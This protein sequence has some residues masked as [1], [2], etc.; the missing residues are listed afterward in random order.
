M[1]FNR[2]FK[3]FLLSVISFSEIH[4]L[5]RDQTY[6]LSTF[7]KISSEPIGVT[8]NGKPDETDKTKFVLKH[9]LFNKDGISKVPAYENTTM[10]ITTGVLRLFKINPDGTEEVIPNFEINNASIPPHRET[11]VKFPPYQITIKYTIDQQGILVI[12]VTKVENEKQIEF[13]A[14]NEPIYISTKSVPLTNA[15]A[16][17]KTEFKVELVGNQNPLTPSNLPQTRGDYTFQGYFN[18]DTQAL[19]SGTIRLFKIGPNNETIEVEDIAL[20]KVQ[21]FGE[22]PLP[23]KDSPYNIILEF[24]YKSPTSGGEKPYLLINIAKAEIDP[25]YTKTFLKKNIPIYISSKPSIGIDTPENVQ[26]KLKILDNQNGRITNEIP[27]TE[28]GNDFQGYFNLD[29]QALTSGSLRLVKIGPNGEEI[30]IPDDKTKIIPRLSGEQ[31]IP[32]DPYYNVNIIFKEPSNEYSWYDPRRLLPSPK[33]LLFNIQS[34]QIDNAKKRELREQKATIQSQIEALQ[35]EIDT[36]AAELDNIKLAIKLSDFLSEKGYK[37]YAHVEILKETYKNSLQNLQQDLERIKQEEPTTAKNSL[38]KARNDFDLLKVNIENLKILNERLTSINKDYFLKAASTLHNVRAED[39]LKRK[40]E[41]TNKLLKLKSISFYNATLE[42]ID[43]LTASFKAILREIQDLSEKDRINLTINYRIQKNPPFEV[44]NS[45]YM[46]ESFLTSNT[47]GNYKTNTT[48]NYYDYWEV[49]SKDLNAVSTLLI[50]SYA[51]KQTDTKF[52]IENPILI[53]FNKLGEQ[54]FSVSD[55]NSGTRF[56]VI[57][58]VS[59]QPGAG[60]EN[61]IKLAKIT[62][63]NVTPGQNDIKAF[64]GTPSPSNWIYIENPMYNKNNIVLSSSN[65]LSDFPELN[66]LN[67]N[68]K[69]SPIKAINNIAFLNLKIADKNRNFTGTFDINLPLKEEDQSMEI[70][71]PTENPNV[72]DIYKITFKLVSGQAHD[73]NFKDYIKNVY[74]IEVTDIQ[75]LESSHKKELAHYYLLQEDTKSNK[76]GDFIANLRFIPIENALVTTF[77]DRKFYEINSNQNTAEVNIELNK[78]SAEGSTI[79]LSDTKKII[80]LTP[81][82]VQTIQDELG[83]NFQITIKETENIVEP[84]ENTI[85]TNH[86]FEVAK[87]AIPPQNEIITQRL[88]PE[89]VEVNEFYTDRNVIVY[90]S[91]KLWEDESFKDLGY[92]PQIS[93]SSYSMTLP[94]GIPNSLTQ[95]GQEYT[96]TSKMLNENS[97]FATPNEVQESIIFKSVSPFPQNK[98]DKVLFTRGSINPNPVVFEDLYG[99]KFICNLELTI[100]ELPI[101]NFKRGISEKGKQFLD[102]KQNNTVEVWFIKIKSVE[103]I[104]SPTARG[105]LQAKLNQEQAQKEKEIKRKNDDQL[106]LNQNAPVYFDL[107]PQKIQKINPAIEATTG[108]V[109]FAL[110][111][112]GKSDNEID[113]DILANHNIPKERDRGT[114]VTYANTQ[115][116]QLNAGSGTVG[117]VA[118]VN[119]Q[120]IPLPNITIPFMTGGYLTE[121]LS[122]PIPVKIPG[123]PLEYI[124]TVAFNHKNEGFVGRGKRLYYTARIASVTYE[125][126]SE[127]LLLAAIDRQNKAKTALEEAKKTREAEIAFL[128]INDPI[129]INPTPF[130]FNNLEFTLIIKGNQLNAQTIL[131]E[132]ADGA[133]FA[134]F[135]NQDGTI[136]SGDLAVTTNAGQIALLGKNVEKTEKTYN[137]EIEG[138]PYI[139]TLDAAYQLGQTIQSTGPEEQAQNIPSKYILNLKNIQINQALLD[140]RAE[141]QRLKAEEDRKAQFLAQNIPVYID[142][143][144]IDSAGKNVANFKLAIENPITRTYPSTANDQAQANNP[145]LSFVNYLNKKDLA[146][147]SFELPGTSNII[148][149]SNGEKIDTLSILQS[150]GNYTIPISRTDENNNVIIYDAQIS[151]SGNNKYIIVKLNSPKYNEAKTKFEEN[152]KATS[153]ILQNNYPIYISRT[154][155]N[156]EGLEFSLGISGE[157]FVTAGIEPAINNNE[158]EGFA[159]KLSRNIYDNRK[160]AL[161]TKDKTIDLTGTLPANKVDPSFVT[162]IAVD[163]NIIPLDVKISFTPPTDTAPYYIIELISIDITE[164]EKANRAEAIALEKFIDENAAVYIDSTAIPS[165]PYSKANQNTFSLKLE[166]PNADIRKG[167]EAQVDGIAFS[168][169]YNKTNNTFETDHKLSV[170]SNNNEINNSSLTKL[171]QNKDIIIP[172]TGLATLDGKNYQIIVESKFKKS[173]IKG[174]PDTYIIKLKEVVNL[175][176]LNQ[177]FQDLTKDEQ[178]TILANNLPLYISGKSA[179][180]PDGSQFTININGNTIGPI[181]PP[182]LVK[183]ENDEIF[184]GYADKATYKI[185]SGNLDIFMNNQPIALKEPITILQASGTR[186]IR[187]PESAYTNSPYIVVLEFQKPTDS[188]SVKI[189]EIKTVNEAILAKENEEAKSDIQALANNL[190]TTLEKLASI[191]NEVKSNNGSIIQSKNAIDRKIQELSNEIKTVKQAKNIAED[192]LSLNRINTDITTLV[193][194]TSDLIFQYNQELTTSIDHNIIK[195]DA[196]KEINANIKSQKD[197]II[198]KSNQLKQFIQTLDVANNKIKSTEI[199]DFKDLDQLIQNL[200]KANSDFES[201][202]KSITELSTDETQAKDNMAFNLNTLRS[203]ATSLLEKIDIELIPSKNANL[204]NIQS[205]TEAKNQ[206]LEQ[207]ITELKNNLNSFINSL[208]PENIKTETEYKAKENEFNTFNTNFDNLKQELATLVDENNSAIESKKNNISNIAKRLLG[209]IFIDNEDPLNRASFTIN[210]AF[211]QDYKD[212]R[213]EVSDL[214]A[215]IS[216]TLDNLTEKNEDLKNSLAQIISYKQESENLKNLITQLIEKNNNL[217]NEET[218]NKTETEILIDQANRLKT[219]VQDLQINLNSFNN[220]LLANKSL[221]PENKFSNRSNILQSDNKALL[222][223]I[224]NILT[225]LNANQKDLGTTRTNLD[226]LQE[227]LIKETKEFNILKSEF[228]STKTSFIQSQSQILNSVQSLQQ[229]IA[230][231]KTQLNGVTTNYAPQTS[232]NIKNF[233]SE[234]N[235]LDSKINQL[236]DNIRSINN[237]KDLE[238]AK[239]E[240]NLY[241]INYND[242]KNQLDAIKYAEKLGSEEFSNTIYNLNKTADTLVTNI[243][244]LINKIPTKI[245]STLSNDMENL[246]KNSQELLTHVRELKTALEEKTLSQVSL[247]Q[248]ERELSEADN[249]LSDFDN[250]LG[251]LITSNIKNINSREGIARKA[252]ELIESIDK[253]PEF[254]IS[255]DIKTISYALETV[256][257]SLQKQIIDIHANLD[258]IIKDINNPRLELDNTKNNVDQIEVNLLKLKRAINSF[259][260]QNQDE[261]DNNIKTERGK[262]TDKINNLIGNIQKNVIDKLPDITDSNLLTDKDTLL[263]E[264]QELVDDI[265]LIEKSIKDTTSETIF[266]QINNELDDRNEKINDLI[267]RINTLIKDNSNN[268]ESKN[269][270]TQKAR[271]LIDIIDTDKDLSI[272]KNIKSATS[273]LDGIKKSYQYQLN[274]IRNELNEKIINKIDSRS[275]D[276]ADAR[277][278]LARNETDIN[279]LKNTINLFLVQNQRELDAQLIPD[280]E[281]LSKQVNSLIDNVNDNIIKKL[282]SITDFGLQ[283]QKASIQKEAEE[284]LTDIN[285]IKKSINASFVTQTIFDQIKEELSIKN[286]TFMDLLRSVDA[287]ERKNTN[288]IESRQKL[289]LEVNQ[290]I[291]TIDNDKNLIIPNNTPLASSEISN[292]KI[293]FQNQLETIRNNLVDISETIN[294]RY[295]FENIQTKVSEAQKIINALK[296]LIPNLLSRNQKELNDKINTQ[297]SGL[298]QETEAL[299]KGILTINDKLAAITDP[300]L[301]VSKATLQGDVDNFLKDLNEIDNSIDN[302]NQSTFSEIKDQLNDKN[303]T[304]TALNQRIGLLATQNAANIESKDKIKNDVNKLLDSLNDSEFII[305][306]D[307]PSATPT[308]DGTKQDLIN[309]LHI[310]RHD[311]GNILN[312]IDTADLIDSERNLDNVQ[313]NIINLKKDIK[314]FLS[315]NQQE[316]SSQIQA[317]RDSLNP[318]ANDLIENIKSNVLAKLPTIM[319]PA[320]LSEKDILAKDAEGFLTDLNNIKTSIN[321]PHTSPIIFEQIKDELII[322]NSDLTTLMQ[323]LNSLINLNTKYLE[324]RTD[325]SAQ[326]QALIDTIDNDPKLKIPSDLK[327]AYPELD[328]IKNFLKNQLIDTRTKLE[329]IIKDKD[330]LQFDFVNTS[331][332]LS[333]AKNNIE[334]LRNSINNFLNRNKDEIDKQLNSNKNTLNQRANALIKDLENQILNKL[335]SLTDPTLINTKNEIQ[336]DAENLLSDIKNIIISI[337]ASNITQPILGQIEEELP[338]RRDRL[339][340]LIQTFNSFLTQNTNTIKSKQN[341]E[342]QAKQLINTIDNDPTL[343]IPTDLQVASSPLDATK[344]DLISQLKTVRQKLHNILNNINTETFA[345]TETGLTEAQQTINILRTSIQEFLTKNNQEFNSQINNIKNDLNSQ[346]DTLIKNTQ[347]EISNKLPSITDLALTIRKNSLQKDTEEFLTDLNKIQTSINSGPLSLFIFNQINDELMSRKTIYN[348]LIK[349]MIELVND[350]QKNIDLRSNIEK[351]ATDYLKD[352]NTNIEYTV[353]KDLEFVTSEIDNTKNKLIDQINTARNGL[354]T[355]IKKAKEVSPKFDELQSNLTDIEKKLPGLKNSIKNFLAQYQKGL[356]IKI[357]ANRTSLNETVQTLFDDIKLKVIDKLPL[358]ADPNLI[359][360]KEEIQK[361]AKEFLT[362]LTKNKEEIADPAAKQADFDRIK[363]TLSTRSEEL[364]KLIQRIE[365][366]ISQNTINKNLRDSI[367]NQAKNMLTSINKDLAIPADFTP[368]AGMKEEQIKLQTTL[369]RSRDQ[370]RAAIT[371]IIT[372]INDKDLDFSAEQNTLNDTQKAINSLNE[373]IQ[374]LIKNNKNALAKEQA[375]REEELKRAEELRKQAL[376]EWTDKFNILQLKNQSLSDP[377][378]LDTKNQIAQEINQ[379]KENLLLDLSPEKNQLTYDAI[380]TKIDSAL[381]LQEKNRQIKNKQIQELEQQLKSLQNQP[382]VYIDSTP[383]KFNNKEFTV[384]LLRQH[385]DKKA[386]LKREASTLEFSGYVNSDGIILPNGFLAIVIK[387]YITAIKDKKLPQN[388]SIIA[389][390]EDEL[391]HPYIVTLN[392]AFTKNHSVFDPNLNL[393]NKDLPNIYIIKLA[394]VQTNEAKINDRIKA[395]DKAKKD[396]L[397][398]KQKT[399]HAADRDFISQN[400]P[401]YINQS[402]QSPSGGSLRL[403]LTTSEGMRAILPSQ[404]DGYR[405]S[406]YASQNGNIYKGDLFVYLNNQVAYQVASGNKPIG[407]SGSQ[408][409]SFTIG[410]ATYSMKIKSE[411]KS[412]AVSAT[413]TKT[414]AYFVEIIPGSIK[415][416]K[417]KPKKEK[418]QERKETK[419][420]KEKKSSRDELREFFR[421]HH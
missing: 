99:N 68:Q 364:T 116:D 100:K 167:V 241:K 119:G 94:A 382:A 356:D 156:A 162:N 10:N 367:G 254:K 340:A 74:L 232:E 370:L 359:T 73:P 375:L 75:Y 368:A 380:N 257:T 276:F 186:E 5:S 160:L 393:S 249:K 195:I 407:K 154:T 409:I 334:R 341:F 405:F 27:E 187:I 169:Y 200:Q 365:T 267:K 331:R 226:S 87:L 41:L 51:T 219:S 112:N 206:N 395:A 62:N 33:R 376:T 149:E 319:D 80:N 227:E 85:V 150:T 108:N 191:S 126:N 345:N 77:N 410:D 315:T 225:D 412:I 175:S 388:G 78:I 237:N 132:E 211:Q 234:I 330:L 384:D 128:K 181:Y 306:A 314:D 176:T 401:I 143:Q 197:S 255:S 139:A 12:G 304:L 263:T 296:S 121:N 137:F 244:N 369:D 218:L 258:S 275:F 189:K 420:R 111:L 235:D 261:L 307:L 324:Y 209:D 168:G 301:K 353:P 20:S 171:L 57:I 273:E 320:L 40:D 193:Q 14:I 43:D 298:K 361:D 312:N 76:E 278:I 48:N 210:K 146:N 351:R 343:H 22:L 400:P 316:L 418:G 204:V 93:L 224:E 45:I 250:V 205:E 216:Q 152:R 13:I 385:I 339:N 326:A 256:K 130:P 63:I 337:N 114:L 317:N 148:I 417:I 279:E 16:T 379:A 70:K 299:N 147:E 142:T 338:S 158:L 26:F 413:N 325:Y 8:F 44:N 166:G 253:D 30:L 363:T 35:K 284:F 170:F 408:K 60:N 246:Y 295:D 294:H 198:L 29:T 280:K 140:Q 318:I 392:V 49:D 202:A 383:F 89:E 415:V 272:P 6:N 329:N 228:E 221:D 196:V 328:N 355:I 347:N 109:Q 136:L 377:E 348:N 252:K 287:L 336:H 297:R 182:V 107:N 289:T 251:S 282:S 131:D 1:N 164:E 192:N 52:K 391:N 399:D 96:F 103:L 102:N 4:C 242:L 378:F 86:L 53:D 95:D 66:Y 322:R 84:D 19:V 277:A 104:A 81:G 402:P 239:T 59:E 372:R 264:A 32:V 288:Y 220:D 309:K 208:V 386:I 64:E 25:K 283:T 313:N 305:P 92:I 153:N 42:T 11:K 403:G 248:I 398:R 303:K 155:K 97:L 335:P 260:T 123:Q 129:Y 47:P 349:R 178:N 262:L 268:I 271:Q 133:K 69:I 79:K 286:T 390:I 124:V 18:K 265:I 17:D 172:E 212:R 381:S 238:D 145:N 183:N 302:A 82:S 222:G 190:N 125:P 362:K 72:F 180:A 371:S 37:P 292:D 65:I 366:L 247:N 28:G 291:D 21:A 285:N 411:L 323:R 229:S 350:N 342:G 2:L 419:E 23:L 194:T 373:A 161:L 184:A 34:V 141:E 231:L 274:N 236:L 406:G 387:D 290:L 54:K 311:L 115:L 157:K 38:L 269:N 110:R 179:P 397:K 354:E 31:T 214:K 215:K 24:H 58:N 243:Q 245:D 127:R 230:E 281:N 173:Q 106:Y 151:F 159:E 117:L 346:V 394:N 203:N 259:L 321:S 233:N 67:T 56:D 332:T 358:I 90:R 300:H 163:G 105:A 134:G 293:K 3:L 120:E 217:N 88:T 396:D 421:K 327:S 15:P 135:A 207:S 177:E 199:I 266:S 50:L 36:A 213:N 101:G 174:T 71:L 310:A 344:N 308:L 404:I 240:F 91:A 201:L 223:N 414:K 352:I 9:V 270:I 374:L 118:I 389:E 55:S 360:T 7:F 138:T 39:N 357:L 185:Y 165:Y 188:L 83:N 98:T 61:T 144:S 46:L 113:E 416:E 333:E 122:K